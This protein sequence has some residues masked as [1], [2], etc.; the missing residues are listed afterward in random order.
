MWFSQLR[1]YWKRKA[2][3]LLWL[4]E[5]EEKKAKR[6][7]NAKTFSRSPAL[8]LIRVENRKK[9][10]ENCSRSLVCVGEEL[11]WWS[12]FNFHHNQP[13]RGFPPAHLSLL[14]LLSFGTHRAHFNPFLFPFASTQ[15]P[16][17]RRH[18]R[19]LNSRLDTYFRWSCEAGFVFGYKNHRLKIA[20]RD[21]RP[22][23]ITVCSVLIV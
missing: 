18:P 19:Q 8:L 15:T 20:S 3:C 5:K 1:F 22:G 7:L 12:I 2:N 17:R 13:W 11:K 23:E 10:E 14:H 4:E 6:K 16:I 21:L 9:S